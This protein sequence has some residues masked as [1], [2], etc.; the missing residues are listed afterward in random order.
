MI[1]KWFSLKTIQNIMINF[2]ANSP[3]QGLQSNL[4]G[5]LEW[6]NID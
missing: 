4:R 1:L 3:Y 6:F 2:K 5:Y